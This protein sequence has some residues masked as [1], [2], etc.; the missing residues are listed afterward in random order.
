MTGVGLV[1]GVWDLRL[2]RFLQRG[3]CLG[4][5]VYAISAK[6]GG[7]FGNCGLSIFCKGGG[8]RDLRFI[9]FLQRRGVWVFWLSRF[10]P[11]YF[12]SG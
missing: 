11:F 10:S 3:G 2:I 4:F 8:V 6:G 5:V 1:V 7:A 9:Q 12:H